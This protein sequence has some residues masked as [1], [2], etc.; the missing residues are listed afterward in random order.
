MTC[1]YAKE[2]LISMVTEVHE[3]G[4]EEPG[5]EIE[6]VRKCKFPKCKVMFEVSGKNGKIGHFGHSECSNECGNI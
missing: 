1:E 3:K 2:T 4:L 5:K 6:V